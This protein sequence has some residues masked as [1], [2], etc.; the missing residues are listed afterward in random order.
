M[1]DL[2]PEQREEYEERA[3]MFEHDGRIPQK[4]AEEIAM[5]LIL[6]KYKKEER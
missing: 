5:R 2:T 6:A 3:A 1:N 4:Q